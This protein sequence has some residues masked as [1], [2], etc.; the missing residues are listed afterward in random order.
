[1][2]ALPSVAV[3]ANRARLK[4]AASAARLVTPRAVAQGS[5]PG[6]SPDGEQSGLALLRDLAFCELGSGKRSLIV[7]RGRLSRLDQEIQIGNLPAAPSPGAG[8]RR[9]FNS[10]NTCAAAKE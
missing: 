2:T 4:P 1:M 8:Y 5:R 6:S 3:R 9:R 10:N 7:T